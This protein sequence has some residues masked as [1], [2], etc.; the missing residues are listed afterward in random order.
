MAVRPDNGQ[1]RY[2]KVVKLPDGRKVRISGTPAF[3]TRVAAEEAERAHV[4]R[5]LDL[6]AERAAVLARPPP[7]WVGRA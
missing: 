3:N 5:V 4:L 7:P 6:Y 1:W 2:R